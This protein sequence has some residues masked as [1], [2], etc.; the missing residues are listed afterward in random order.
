MKLLFY[1]IIIVSLF[2]VF[3][4]CNRNEKDDRLV[5]SPFGEKSLD[6][7]IYICK[8]QSDLQRNPYFDTTSY[9]V[10]FVFSSINDTNIVQVMGMYEGAFVFHDSLGWNKDKFLGFF[11]NGK[12]YCLFYQNLFNK[13]TS[14]DDSYKFPIANKFLQDWRLR[15]PSENPEIFVKDISALSQDPYIFEYMVDTIGNISLIRKGHW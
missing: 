15:K 1:L 9:Y 8:Q 3:A 2:S 13:H 14:T 6:E 4:S 12:Y 10:T 7:M 5:N 11:K